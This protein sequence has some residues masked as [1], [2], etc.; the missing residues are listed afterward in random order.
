MK[1]IPV[2]LKAFL[3]NSIIGMCVIV[4]FVLDGNG[5]FT[6]SNDFN[7]QEIS[8]NILMNNSI[9]SGEVLWNTGID[10]GSN[11]IESFGFYNLG[12]PFVWLSLLFPASAVPKVIPWMFILKFAVAGAASAL[13]FKRHS[14]NELA[15]L[16]GSVLYAFSGYQCSS[17][18]FYHFQDMV[19]LFPF[20][21]IGL[22]KLVEE[23]KKGY[24]AL[25]CGF[26]C[27]ANLVFFV[28]DV[29]FLILFFV[30]RYLIPAWTSK[31]K[32]KIRKNLFDI[33]FCM[34]EGFVGFLISG[35]IT[36]PV[37][38]GLLNV[39]RA[40][41]H[42]VPK[43][44]FTISSASVLTSLKAFFLPGELMSYPSSVWGNDWMTNAAYLPVVGVVFVLAYCIKKKDW[45]AQLLKVCV[46]ISFVPVLNN[47]FAMASDSPYRRWY[48]MLILFMVLATIKVIEKPTEYPVKKGAIISLL[49]I[50]SFMFFTLAMPWS[51][52]TESVIFEPAIYWYMI[53][54]SVA[55]IGLSVWYSK[56]QKQKVLV[57]LVGIFAVITMSVNI[58]RSQ[59]YMDDSHLKFKEL[60]NE[61]G[62]SV[63]E[64]VITYLTE[65]SGTLEADIAPYRYYFD[66]GIW[67]SYYNL[68]MTNAL[69]T[70]N[71]FT[72]TVNGSIFRFY[73]TVGSERGTMTPNEILGVQELLGA[74]YFIVS[75]YLEKSQEYA[76]SG[77]NLIIQTLPP[78]E[79]YAAYECI[80][81]Y[82]DQNGFQFYMY[83]NPYALPI[84]FAYDSYILESELEEIAPQFR[85]IVMLQAMVVADEDEAAVSDI[86]QH[87]DSEEYNLL[88]EGYRVLSEKAEILTEE[89]ELYLQEQKLYAQELFCD[90]ISSIA[91]N[92]QTNACEEFEYGHNSFSA[93][94]IS[95]EDCYT[96]FSIPYDRFWH[97]Y[98]DGE[99]VQILDCAGLMAIRTEAGDK[100]IEFVYDYLPIKIGVIASC[101]GIAGWI[102]LGFFDRK[103]RTGYRKKSF[104]RR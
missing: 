48:Y 60:A 68:G 22:E 83:D 76:D 26:N 35:I 100:N 91:V 49:A 20:L 67:K 15:I 74:K 44:W 34:C 54:L 17:M 71:S 94:K 66:E 6:L 38:N 21:M 98:V 1:R 73:E 30:I 42:L 24:L 32:E 103:N 88:T 62:F 90:I 47:T 16:I 19:A 95:E 7:A 39:P 23:Q 14:E 81:T 97:A 101:M 58:T 89:Q 79:K 59:S 52:G 31:D 3:I 36:I 72:T 51:G 50:G 45:L 93:R 85:G 12:S 80:E 33:G 65:F 64:G 41:Q 99:E 25:A 92:R 29:L 46:I 82:T 84:G 96:F 8:F 53:L 61:G 70:T 4:P 9:K 40:A 28:G 13:Y 57:W 10:I 86:M 69:Q 63:S 5:Y 56:K 77:E 102:C 27:L 78:T 55:G 104:Q 37:V 75:D 11:F 18:L 43:D 87:F 2:W